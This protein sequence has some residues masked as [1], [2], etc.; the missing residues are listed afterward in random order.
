MSYNISVD[1][2]LQIFHKASLYCN[3]NIYLYLFVVMYGIVDRRIALK[4]PTGARDFLLHQNFQTGCGA[5]LASYPFVTAVS[6]GA[7]RPGREADRLPLSCGGVK[8]CE[9]FHF[10]PPSIRLLGEVLN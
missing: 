4:F 1:R 10:Q 3:W 6:S 2:L 7:K 5:H 8:K 9:E